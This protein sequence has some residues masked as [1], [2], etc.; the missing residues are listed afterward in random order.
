[1]LGTPLRQVGAP[2]RRMIVAGC[3]AAL[4]AALAALVALRAYYL[5]ALEGL[6]ADGGGLLWAIV[7]GVVLTAIVIAVNLLAVGRKVRN[8]WGLR[9]SE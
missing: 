1:M 6:G 3:V 9:I 8:A 7:V 2:Y 4:V 5:G